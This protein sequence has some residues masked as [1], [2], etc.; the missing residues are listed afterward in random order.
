MNDGMSEWMIKWMIK[1]MWRWMDEWWMM[2]IE[3]VSLIG[4]LWCLKTPLLVA[5]SNKR[6]KEGIKLSTSLY[7]DT[8]QT[9]PWSSLCL[10]DQIVRFLMTATL[11]QRKIS[12][13]WAIV[14]KPCSRQLQST[15]DSAWIILKH[16]ANR[17]CANRHKNGLIQ[18]R[19]QMHSI[20]LG[21]EQSRTAHLP[22]SQQYGINVQSCVRTFLATLWGPFC[23]AFACDSQPDSWDAPKALKRLSALK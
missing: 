4:C 2:I 17:H 8:N 19:A 15:K 7:D 1:W 14:S 9:H 16:T 11:L 23:C 18:H 21:A 22:P 20:K 12:I 5:A 6:M 13:T 10:L 3:Q